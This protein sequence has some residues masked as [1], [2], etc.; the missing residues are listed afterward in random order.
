MSSCVG[1]LCVK[2]NVSTAG[3]NYRVYGVMTKGKEGK[4]RTWVTKYRLKSSTDKEE[5]TYYKEHG[6][7]KVRTFNSQPQ[8]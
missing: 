3:D 7:P 4:T 8:V 6:E 2:F 1:R 5:W